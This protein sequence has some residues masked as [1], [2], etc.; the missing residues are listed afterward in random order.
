MEIQKHDVENIV[1]FLIYENLDRGAITQQ[2]REIAL[3]ADLLP[4][5]WSGGK[6]EVMQKV[7]R[8]VQ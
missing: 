7:E 8:Y 4:A 6:M 3:N 5:V 1:P 2:S